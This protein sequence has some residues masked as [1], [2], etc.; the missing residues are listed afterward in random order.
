WSFIRR[1]R[2]SSIARMTTGGGDTRTRSSIFWAMV[3]SRG[4]RR[5]GSASTS[6][7]SARPFPTKRGNRSARRF[8]A[9]ICIYAVTRP[10]KICRGCSIQRSVAGCNITGGI[11]AR[12]CIPICVNWTARW[13]IGRI[14]NTKSCAVIYGGRHI[15]LRAFPG[16][17]RSCSLTGRWACG[18]APWREPYELRG[19]STVLREAR[20][21]IPRAYSP[22]G[23]VDDGIEGEGGASTSPVCDEQA[24]SGAASGEDADG[25]ATAREGKFRVSRVY[26]PQEA[27]YTAEP[28]VV[29]YAPLAVAQGHETAPGPCSGDH[30]FAAKR[31]GCEA[32]HRGTESR[33]S[34][35]GE[36]LS[37]RH[38]FAGVSAVSRVLCKR[39]SVG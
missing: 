29:F 30:R 11:I 7:T 27:Q 33:A 26:D 2:R 25:G 13:P 39:L 22:R 8:E 31:E 14:G 35:L 1:R 20:G 3:F 4:D 15:G 34:W 21:E 17:I 19:S 23:D 18:V 5:I 36:L 32:G 10:S 9:G 24:G 37:N 28:A 16:V 6:S 12:R 38:L